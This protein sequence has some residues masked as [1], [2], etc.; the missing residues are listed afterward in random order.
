MRWSFRRNNRNN[1]NRLDSDGLYMVLRSKTKNESQGQR[2]FIPFCE[3]Q[4]Y[5]KGFE[6]RSR[7]SNRWRNNFLFQ[8]HFL[9]SSQQKHPTTR[10]EDM[11][12]HQNYLNEFFKKATFLQEKSQTGWL[13]WISFEYRIQNKASQKRKTSNFLQQ[14]ARHFETR[15]HNVKNFHIWPQIAR[16]LKCFVTSLTF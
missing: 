1:R 9:R 13:T 4:I 7:R 3:F 2:V 16:F 14:R 11:V 12:S 6:S 5:W 10:F 15:K 8:I